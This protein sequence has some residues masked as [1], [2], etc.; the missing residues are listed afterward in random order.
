MSTTALLRWQFRR[1]H[2]FLDAEF[3]SIIAEAAAQYARLTV[4]EDIIINGILAAGEPLAY[5][6]WR[7]QTGLSELPSLESP[8]ERQA[9]TQRVRVQPLAF[10]AYALAVHAAADAY[11]RQLDPRPAGETQRRVLVALLL[12]MSAM[13]GEVGTLR[14]A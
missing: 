5:S 6:G 4:Y 3:D 1:V 11:L 10:R 12:K 9:W 13:R 8:A 7:G 14:G 2:Q